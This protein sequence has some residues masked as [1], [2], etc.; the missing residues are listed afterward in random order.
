MSIGTLVPCAWALGLVAMAVGCGGKKAKPPPGICFEKRANPAAPVQPAEW[1]D[2]IVKV[3]ND[4]RQLTAMYDCTGA[5]IRWSPPP[6]T[7]IV[8]SPDIGQPSPVPL[9]EESVVERRLAGDER[10]VWVITHRFANGDGFGPVGLVKILRRGIAVEALGPLRLRTDRINMELWQIGG[11][12]VMVATGETCYDKR[13]PGSCHRASNVLVLRQNAF[14]DPPI[15]Y[16][17]GRCI[18]APWVELSRRADLP[19]DSGWNRHFEITSTLSHDERYLVI[20]EQVLVEDSDPDAP[21]VP[22]REVRRVDTQRFIH[23]D[24]GRLVTRQHPLWPK[25]LPVAGQV[26]VLDRSKL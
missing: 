10:L 11:P 24:A 25:I 1:L 9:T 22:A 14:L 16:N 21:D 23:L 12:E 18:D 2:L 26:E 8:K 20:T 17:D 13:D 3:N 15:T 5:I 4:G 7:C 19:L 6:Q